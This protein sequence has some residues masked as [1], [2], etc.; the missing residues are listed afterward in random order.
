MTCK[1]VFHNAKHFIQLIVVDTICSIF[2]VGILFVELI[3]RSST[4]YQQEVSQ[5]L[6]ALLAEHIVADQPL[7]QSQ[8]RNH[9]VLDGL[10]HN[11]MAI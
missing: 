7:I 3:G 5:I 8:K 6:N 11:L 9:Q 1:R 10:F 4:L 2:P